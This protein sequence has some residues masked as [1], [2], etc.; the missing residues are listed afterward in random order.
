M[1]QV[2]SLS[3]MV[4]CIPSKGEYEAIGAGFAR[5]ARSDE[6]RCV[7]GAIHGCH[8]EVM[9]SGPNRAD[10]FSRKL[11]YSIQFQAVCDHMGK[12]VDVFAEYPG[13][14]H[15]SRVF[16]ASLLYVNALYPPQGYAI[17]GDSGYPCIAEP[18]AVLTPYRE[19]VA[20]PIQARF[21]AH[22]RRGR[23]IIERSFGM[24][25]TRWNCIFMKRVTLRHTR[26]ANVIGACCIMHNICLTNGD[27]LVGGELVGEEEYMVGMVGHHENGFN[28]RDNIA[29]RMS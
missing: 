5:M 1:R 25:K 28:L 17:L 6:L 8:V 23:N 2:L 15:Y 7:V 3:G 26:V 10:Y 21:N 9:P 11:R 13:S 4:I 14:V 29:R 18:I 22:H 20:G 19:P 27:I 12:F 16:M 24:L